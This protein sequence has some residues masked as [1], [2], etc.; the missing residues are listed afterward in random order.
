M[1]EHDII[2]ISERIGVNR[3]N[4]SKECAICIIGIF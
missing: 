4:A 2:A 3:T 1:L